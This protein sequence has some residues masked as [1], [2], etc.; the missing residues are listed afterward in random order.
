MNSINE[1]F[2][3]IGELLNKDYKKAGKE[4]KKLVITKHEVKKNKKGC[5]CSMK[6]NDA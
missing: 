6:A 4:Q 5:V 3:E 1:L 2:Q